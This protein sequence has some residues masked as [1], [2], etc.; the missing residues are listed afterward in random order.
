[1]SKILNLVVLLKFEE[2]HVERLKWKVLIFQAV[3][4]LTSW[5]RHPLKEMTPMPVSSISLK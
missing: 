2:I 5:S 4:S 3:I 1:M